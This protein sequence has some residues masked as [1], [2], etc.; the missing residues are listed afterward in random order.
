MMKIIYIIEIFDPAN[1]PWD[2]IK[3]EMMQHEHD[4]LYGRQMFIDMWIAS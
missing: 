3:D 4:S 1:N 2:Q